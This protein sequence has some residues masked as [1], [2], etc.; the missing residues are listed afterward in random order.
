MIRP[1]HSFGDALAPGAKRHGAEAAAKPGPASLE[2][3][4]GPPFRRKA[5]FARLPFSS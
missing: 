3:A 4:R 2:R 1:F 5:R